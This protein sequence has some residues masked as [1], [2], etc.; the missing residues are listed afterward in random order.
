MGGNF[1]KSRSKPTSTANPVVEPVD[2]AENLLD[3]TNE[4]SDEIQ[5]ESEGKLQVILVPHV[6][7]LFCERKVGLQMQNTSQVVIELF[8][9]GFVLLSISFKNWKLDC[10]G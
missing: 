7:T 8:S 2:E 1:S 6:H 10:K 5:I 9:N 3:S 4:E